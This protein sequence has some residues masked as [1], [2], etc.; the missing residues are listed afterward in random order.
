MQTHEICL[1]FKEQRDYI[2]GTDVFNQ[3]LYFFPEKITHIRLDLKKIIKG[4]QGLMHITHDLEE[5]R[6]CNS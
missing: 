1:T 3:I 4:N 5:H 6:A 2:Q